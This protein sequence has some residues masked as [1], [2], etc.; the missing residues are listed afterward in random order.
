MA[1]LWIV[2]FAE[3]FSRYINKNLLIITKSFLYFNKL[4]S[5]KINILFTDAMKNKL[6]EDSKKFYEF[7]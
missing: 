1:W 5:Q 4:T 3:Y 7:K 2:I 6:K